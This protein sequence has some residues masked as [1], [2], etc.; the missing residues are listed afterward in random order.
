[1][2][3]RGRQCY[4]KAWVS[5]G[6]RGGVGRREGHGFEIITEGAGKFCPQIASW[7]RANAMNALDIKGWSNPFAAALELEPPPPG[8]EDVKCFAIPPWISPLSFDP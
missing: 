8:H 2:N 6:N 3:G 1:M 5:G 7:S 4:R